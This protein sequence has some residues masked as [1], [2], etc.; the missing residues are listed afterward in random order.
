MNTNNILN[1]I[2]YQNY[3]FIFISPPVRLGH[4]K[5]VL[6]QINSHF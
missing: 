5:R 2:Y 3:L 4:L 6:G 1:S